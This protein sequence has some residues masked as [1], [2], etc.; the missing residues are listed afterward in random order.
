MLYLLLNCIPKEEIFVFE[1]TDLRIVLF[2]LDTNA[3]KPIE[4]K[5]SESYVLSDTFYD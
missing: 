4:S 5:L 3:S 1:G 2:Y